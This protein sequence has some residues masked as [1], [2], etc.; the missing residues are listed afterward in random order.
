MNLK[1]GETNINQAIAIFDEQLF[2]MRRNQSIGRR[3]M[4]K[5]AM[6]TIASSST[7]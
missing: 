7:K 3:L 1:R 4:L 6:T 5:T 2:Q